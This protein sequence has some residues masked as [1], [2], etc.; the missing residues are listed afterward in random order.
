M[1]AQHAIELR[2]IY[3]GYS[4]IKGFKSLLRTPQIVL[5]DINLQISE[6][7]R[8]AIIGESGSGK[9]T[10]LKVILGLLSPVQGEVLINGVS[11]YNLT[12]R[13]RVSI[14]RRI[15]YVPQDPYRALNPA[16][17]VNQI[18]E[19]PLEAI[20]QNDRKIEQEIDEILKL[21]QLPSTVLGLTSDELSGGMRQRV[22][23]ARALI[24]Q[25]SILILDEPTSALDVSIQAQIINLLNDIY[26]RLRITMI[27]VTHDLAVAQYLAD[28]AILIKNGVIVE[29]GALR[30]I[31]SS[32]K[33]EY[34]RAIVSSYYSLRSLM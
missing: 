6:R 10:L 4:V 28:R 20:G 9:T 13:K 17:S 16:L 25:P 14:L 29:D 31:L 1:S 24:H 7:E 27:T 26:S 22:L 11:I 15:G 18:L 5:K 32:P 12:W 23:I 19:E 8:V 21:V 2:K 30:D 34:A 3:A 33:S